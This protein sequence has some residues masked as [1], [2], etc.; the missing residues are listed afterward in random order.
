MA[1]M[2]IPKTISVIKA[3]CDEAGFAENSF[4]EKLVAPGLTSTGFNPVKTFCEFAELEDVAGSEVE[5][6]SLIFIVC[7]SWPA[8]RSLRNR[9]RGNTHTADQQFSLREKL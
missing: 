2:R 6:R 9:S 4:A 7:G 5:M 1:T 8:W 3:P